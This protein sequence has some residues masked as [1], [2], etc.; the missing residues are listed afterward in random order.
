VVPA[1]VGLVVEDAGAVAESA[2]T[3]AADDVD[4]F[5][6][7]ICAAVEDAGVFTE[8]VVEAFPVAV[9]V[10]EPIVLGAVTFCVTA[11]F[12]TYRNRSFCIKGGSSYAW[13]ETERMS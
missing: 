3:A 12:S 11:K 4:V 8:D 9:D 1:D 2:D 13:S 10:A 5:P 6:E 7:V